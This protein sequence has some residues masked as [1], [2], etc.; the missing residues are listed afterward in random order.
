MRDCARLFA[1]GGEGSP[2]AGETLRAGLSAETIASL[3]SSFRALEGECRIS[4]EEALAYLQGA[5]LKLS[6]TELKRLLN[7]G[8]QYFS[9]FALRLGKR[10]VAPSVKQVDGFIVH[11][12]LKEAYQSVFAKPDRPAPEAGELERAFAAA[13]ENVFSQHPIAGEKPFRTALRKHDLSDRLREFAEL[14]AKRFA[15]RP[16]FVPL[17]FEDGFT[18]TKEVGGRAV[19]FRGAI[20]RIDV[21]SAARRAFVLDYKLNS[22]PNHIS[23]LR[24][25]DAQTPVYLWAAEQKLGY[26]PD[27]IEFVSV[28]QKK[29]PG[30][31]ARSIPGEA[32]GPAKSG[33]HAEE[34]FRAAL[35]RMQAAIGARLESLRA[36]DIRAESVKCG[37]CDYHALCRFEGW[38]Y[39]K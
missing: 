28:K 13:F 5:S 2:E 27:G 34:E 25:D 30:R 12:T 26:P 3:A 4:G 22:A 7:C 37:L 8:Y 31:F 33:W 16:G 23:L 21:N 29:I 9:D 24:G 11:Q 1:I 18:F 6:A 36:G 17:H 10:S 20:D 19:S 35:D 15:E 14:E 38:K 32:S 39:R